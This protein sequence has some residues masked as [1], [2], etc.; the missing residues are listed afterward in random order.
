[1]HQL[2]ISKSYGNRVIKLS[3]LEAQILGFLRGFPNALNGPAS[4]KEEQD[5]ERNL[6]SS[7]GLY[8]GE[9]LLPHESDATIQQKEIALHMLRGFGFVGRTPWLGKWFLTSEGENFLR[10]P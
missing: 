3:F 9:I 4:L 6:G 5:T 2:G 1:V 10:S 8:V 7:N